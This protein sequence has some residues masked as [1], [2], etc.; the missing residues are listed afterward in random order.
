MGRST[1]RDEHN[2]HVS[3]QKLGTAIHIPQKNHGQ[4]EPKA[5]HRQQVL[6]A[7]NWFG[8]DNFYPCLVLKL[9]G[10]FL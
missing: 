10:R 7:R 3:L 8:V 2:I 9:N 6:Q 1:R 4:A 5:Q